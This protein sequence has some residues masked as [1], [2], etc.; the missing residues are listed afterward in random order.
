MREHGELF[1][2]TSDNVP[3]GSFLVAEVDDIEKGM[4]LKNED[5]KII[6]ASVDASLADRL[7]VIG[8]ARKLNMEGKNV[9][10]ITNSDEGVQF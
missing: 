6:Y 2:G 4:E 3:K 9:M 8:L 1:L 5:M 10:L 7:A